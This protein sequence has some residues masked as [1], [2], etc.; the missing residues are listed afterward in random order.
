MAELDDRLALLEKELDALRKIKTQEDFDE[1]A[2]LHAEKNSPWIN[3]PYSHLKFPPYE[4][5][6]FPKMLYSL[7]YEGA[8]QEYYEATLI[9]ARGSEE[10]DRDAAM[11]KAQRRK[12]TSTVIVKTEAEFHRL[13]AS[14][15]WYESPGQAIG[16][17]KAKQD[18]I[19]RQ[20][21]HLA[22]D[23]RHLGA[24]ARREREAAD[25]ASDGHLVEVRTP[26]KRG[27]K[28]RTAAPAPVP[29]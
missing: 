13:I 6:A 27:R 18:E 29:A 17:M 2:R 8:C 11:R 16:A 14:G 4:F 12:D 26:K 21:A 23:D 7:D 19:G 25:E 1:G 15:D 10:G 28:P 5:K 20:A 3:G 9:P 22:Y 24:A